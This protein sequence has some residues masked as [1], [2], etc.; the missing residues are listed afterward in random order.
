MHRLRQDLLEDESPPNTTR[1]TCIAEAR[2]VA[3][4]AKRG[5]GAAHVADQDFIPTHVSDE[6]IIGFA[7][8]GFLGSCADAQVMH[9]CEEIM[10]E[11]HGHTQDRVLV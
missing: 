1:T 3:R 4:N 5:W 7:C 11:L 9:P 6:P 10:L 8:D 2:H